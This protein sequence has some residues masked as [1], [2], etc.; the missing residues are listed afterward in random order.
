MYHI[1]IVL[2]IDACVMCE[3]NDITCNNFKEYNKKI[4]QDDINK[5]G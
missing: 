5:K 1:L 3:G 2:A 4:N